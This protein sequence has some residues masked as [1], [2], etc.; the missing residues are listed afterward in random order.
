MGPAVLPVLSAATRPVTP[1]YLFNFIAN[2]LVPVSHM[3]G[4]KK[5]APPSIA[6]NANKKTARH[7]CQAVA[8]S[9]RG[10]V[11]R[12]AK[13]AVDIIASQP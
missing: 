10:L 13:R 1:F 6:G 3:A 5:G 11:A 4:G 12:C 2:V 8:A 9:G 7:Y